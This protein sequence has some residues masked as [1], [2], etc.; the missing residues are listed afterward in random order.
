MTRL[1]GFGFLD[2]RHC[3]KTSFIAFG[4]F[5]A[6]IAFLAIF[7]IQNRLPTVDLP[8]FGTQPF[9]FVA[10]AFLV[11]GYAGV[12][13]YKITNNKKLTLESVIKF[14]DAKA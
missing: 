12:I 1:G 3:E 8:F 13:Y 5:V 4:G 7:L 10:F 6:T 2:S 11:G 9:L 14:W